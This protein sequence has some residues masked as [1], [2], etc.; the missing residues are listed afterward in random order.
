MVQK[1]S[2]TQVGLG[3]DW[4]RVVCGTNSTTALKT[5]GTL[6]TWG[7]GT[8][9]Q[10]ASGATT[11]RSSPVQV[12]GTYIDI[13]MSGTNIYAI[14]ST[15][16]LWSAGP[17]AGLP[18]VGS[19][20]ASSLVQCVGLVG[21]QCLSFPTAV[22]S[23]AAGSF[24]W[25]T[26]QATPTPSQSPTPTPT[27]SPTSAAL[28]LWAF[29]YNN[30]GQIGDN[31]TVSKSLPV[32]IGTY[33]LKT[34]TNQASQAAGFIVDGEVAYGWGANNA[35][36]LGDGT[37]INKSSPSIIPLTNPVSLAFGSSIALKSNNTVWVWGANS[38]GSLGQND[39]VNRSSPVQLNTGAF[40]PL[41]TGNHNRQ[42]GYVTTTGL[43]F[44]AGINSFGGL[45]VN[46]TVNRSSM[47]QV[48]ISNVKFCD[49]GSDQGYWV[50][51]DNTLW[52]AGINNL[53][54][55]GTNTTINYSS[56]I[57]ITT[58]V[59]KFAAGNYTC[60]LL[61]TDGTLWMWGDNSFGECGQNISTTIS[62]PTQVGVSNQWIDFSSEVST[63]LALKSDNT[64]WAWGYN[65]RGP[66]GNN[67][68]ANVS[69]PTQI[70]IGY[71]WR[72]VQRSNET[73]FAWSDP[74]PSPSPTA[75]V[76][77]SPTP[78]PSASPEPTPSPTP[79]PSPS[80][81]E[82][83]TPSPS[84]SP[85][86]SPTP[87]PTPS[88]TNSPTPSGSATRT[89]TPTP[90]ATP[91]PVLRAWYDMSDINNLW[92]NTARTTPI[93]TDGQ[94]IQGI[95]D[96]SG[97]G[98]N[99]ASVGAQYGGLYKVNIMNGL[100]TM[101]C[102]WN[103]PANSTYLVNNTGF[104]DATGFTLVCAIRRTGSAN[105]IP[106][107]AGNY[108]LGSGGSRSIFIDSSDFFGFT[109]K[110]TNYMSTQTV[111]LNT[112]CVLMAT[113]DLQTLKLYYNGTEVL[114]TAASFGTAGQN[115]LSM[116]SSTS[117]PLPFYGYIGEA[118]YWSWILTDADRD[119]QNAALVTKWGA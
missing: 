111:A 65:L 109:I 10:L 90:S 107:S 11:N 49:F 63:T 22:G 87:T 9:G 4:S 72:K 88:V 56:P 82:S 2:P 110:G 95:T 75:S 27:P 46:D 18:D 116:G 101:Q 59:S 13:K 67:S 81:T 102:G 100:S 32:Q 85:S 41:Q 31:S 84:P 83:P 69:S 93:T 50:K 68:T 33:Q 98:N 36:Q 112:N 104:V 94:N 24:V 48:L 57:Q 79:S 54:Q 15:G 64:L 73:S 1:N 78:S 42:T 91:L 39:T 3:T 19:V 77:P 89:P 103:A 99:S 21:Y 37:V 115:R 35:G 119:A 17:L 71:T 60:C 20:N 61:K 23:L 86:E 43:P 28:T 106:L 16:K 38:Y 34:T 80:V 114:S 96:D 47:T 7:T 62:S 53:G 12:A 8:N 76:T 55:L 92:Q 6:W 66:V 52:G 118:K 58:G 44:A 105:Q 45:G 70:G 97:L 29:G 30:V 14:D 117:G 26:T 113:Y 25:A 74:V 108:D 40:T 5:N 51:N